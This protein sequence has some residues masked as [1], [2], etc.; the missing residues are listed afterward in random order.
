M[1][2][3]NRKLR[4]LLILLVQACC[5]SH[6]SNLSILFELSVLGFVHFGFHPFLGR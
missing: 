1:I 5:T 2:V 4:L 6:M 3:V